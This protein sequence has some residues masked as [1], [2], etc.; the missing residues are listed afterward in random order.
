MIFVNRQVVAEPLHWHEHQERCQPRVQPLRNFGVID[1]DHVVSTLFNK[2]N[3]A[4][5]GVAT[6]IIAEQEQ[7]RN[8]RFDNLQRA[9]AELSALDGGEVCVGYFH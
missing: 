5:G 1:D 6:F 9:M 7:E 4:F 2:V 8:A 3:G